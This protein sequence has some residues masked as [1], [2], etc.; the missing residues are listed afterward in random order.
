MNLLDGVNKVVSITCGVAEAEDGDRLV[1]Q[2][3]RFDVVE[4]FVPVGSAALGIGASMPRW[5]ANYESV[6]CVETRNTRLTYFLYF[7]CFARLFFRTF[8]GTMTVS[9]EKEK[10]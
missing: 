9:L 6:V 1:L 8:W 10:F 5:G 3:E 7:S 2:I 4:K